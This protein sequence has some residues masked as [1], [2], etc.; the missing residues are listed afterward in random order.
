VAAPKVNA[1]KDVHA[2]KGPF[3]NGKGHFI[4]V[5]VLLSEQIQIVSGRDYFAVPT[6]DSDDLHR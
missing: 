6:Y 2:P 4:S 3:S 1:G 5:N